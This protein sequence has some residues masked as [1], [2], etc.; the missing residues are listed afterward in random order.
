ME[1]NEEA[2]QARYRVT[3]L[4]AGL[5]ES[6]ARKRANVM[7]A[8]CRINQFVILNTEVVARVSEKEVV[9]R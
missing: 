8:E 7:A 6:D 9:H 3:E 2:G 4:Q 5:R 1:V